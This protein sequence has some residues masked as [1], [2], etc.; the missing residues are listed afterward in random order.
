[1]RKNTELS[2]Q[3]MVTE[4][5]NEIKELG[6][7]EEILGFKTNQ[8][9]VLYYLNYIHTPNVFRGI[10]ELPNYYFIKLANL[11]CN[12]T[13]RI[14]IFKDK[15]YDAD[16]NIAQQFRQYRR[17]ILDNRENVDEYLGVMDKMIK[18][19]CW[20]ALHMTLEELWLEPIEQYIFDRIQNMIHNGCLDANDIYYWY[21]SGRNGKS[22]ATQ[23][24]QYIK[25]LHK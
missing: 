13:E 14:N 10:L 21:Q 17:Y 3:D 20:S 8:D 2:I 12:T 25:S 23:S 18:G 9:K 5:T 11:L 6:L 1:M 15:F 4:V 19:E 24:T 16:G 7:S 22:I